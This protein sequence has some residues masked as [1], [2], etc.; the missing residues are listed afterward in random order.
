M[1]ELKGESRVA[2]PKSDGEKSL[3][4]LSPPPPA[5]ATQG[6][7]TETEAVEVRCEQH[8]EVQSGRSSCRSGKGDLGLRGVISR[9]EDRS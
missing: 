7:L 2:D 6:A 8:P 3:P 9:G 5:V 4:Y 1:I